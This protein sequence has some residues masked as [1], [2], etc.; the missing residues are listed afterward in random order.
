MAER[1]I[2]L[3]LLTVLLISVVVG[4]AFADTEIVLQSDDSNVPSKIYIAAG[5]LYSTADG[6]KIIV[7]PVAEEIIIVDDSAKT[8][9][10]IDQ[11]VVAQMSA[12]ISGMAQTLMSQ[13]PPEMLEQMAPEQREA[14]QKLNQPATDAE[15]KMPTIVNTGKSKTVNGI[16]CEIYSV[17]EN[18]SQSGSS[19]CAASAK[20]AKMNG[21]DYATLMKLGDFVTELGSKFAESMPQMKDELELSI[22]Q[23]KLPGVPMEMINDDSVTQIISIT[24]K[25]VDTSDYNT[26]GYEKTDIGQMFSF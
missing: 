3:Y 1:L 16:K 17:K 12:L 8:Y 20:A 14:L 23:L 10:V 15:V 18:D 6:E 19:I 24:E 26:A 5:K 7:D 22:M 11:A 25:K 13:I 21:D 4:Q 9:T 2:K